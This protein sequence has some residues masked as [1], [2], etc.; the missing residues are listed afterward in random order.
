MICSF[1]SLWQVRWQ[2]IAR[3]KA[4]SEQ[5]A[6]AA[7]FAHV[8]LSSRFKFASSMC[9]KKSGQERSGRFKTMCFM[10]DA[11]ADCHGVASSL[12]SIFCQ[13]V[14]LCSRLLATG[15]PASLALLFR[16]MQ[17]VGFALCHPGARNASAEADLPSYNRRTPFRT[18]NLKGTPRRK[19]S[20]RM[21][22]TFSGAT[23]RYRSIEQQSICHAD[24][25]W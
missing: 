16:H 17:L 15:T 10:L 8:L 2:C 11:D 4:L 20:I 19:Q 5:Y 14:R 3:L 13:T 6:A 1:R 23:C 18:A 7:L 21:G 24:F 12:A 25:F 22:L 9:F